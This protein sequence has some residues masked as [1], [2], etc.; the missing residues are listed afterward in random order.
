MLDQQECTETIHDPDVR[1]PTLDPENWGEMRGLGH[2]M[3]DDTFDWLESVRERS[4]WQPMSTAA[5]ALLDEP[6]PIEGEDASTV[7]GQFLRAVRAFPLGNVHPRFWAWVI[8]TGS[9][10]GVLA[11]M[12]S[13]AMNVNVVGGDH[14]ATRVELQVL[15]WS[16]EMVGFPADASGI[17]VSGGSI[18]NLVGLTVALR[19]RAS[20]DVTRVGVGAAGREFTMYAS[21]E[22]HNSV[23]KA[24]GLLGLGTDALRLIPC[25][26]RFEIDVPALACAIADDRA[27]GRQPIAVVGNAGTVN[28]GAI[29][30]LAALADLCER[31]DLW[32]HIDGAIGAPARLSPEITPLFRGLERADSVAFDFHKWLYVPYDAGCILVR[33]AAAHRAAFTEPAAYLARTSRGLWSDD[34]VAF[35]D[36]GIELSRP[37]RALK[38]W[39]ALKTLGARRHAEC[40]EANVSQAKL[41]ADLVQADEDLELLAPVPLNIVC[42]RFTAPGVFDADLDAINEEI[43]LGLQEEGIAVVMQTRVR[44]KLALRTAITNHRSRPE[45]FELLAREVAGRGRRLLDDRR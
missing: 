42:F 30:P 22:T 14:A 40:I 38:I 33:D 19:A 3:L 1:R 7:Y 41:L 10:I 35:G 15:D 31:E 4:V 29:D 11:E 28:T 25:N 13:A 36:Y 18:A 16:K 21:T 6:L 12:L 5:R 34:T 26:D 24:V 17:L 9:P 37:F 45:D 43:L 2:R 23:R 39:M 27:A 44:G 8:G 20:A 32:L